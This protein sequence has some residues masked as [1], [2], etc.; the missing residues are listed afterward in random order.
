LASRGDRATQIRIVGAEDAAATLHV[1]ARV[2]EK[3][4]RAH[5]CELL[6]TA[7]SRACVPA[8]IRTLKEPALRKAALATLTRTRA[9]GV[10]PWKRSRPSRR[11][12]EQTPFLDLTQIGP[13]G[14]LL[15]AAPLGQSGQDA[16]PWRSGRLA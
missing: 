1:V 16:P 15:G 3:P 7:G 10:L 5:A 2:P 11:A 9:T 13:A 12:A 4:D 14:P 6:R 8:M